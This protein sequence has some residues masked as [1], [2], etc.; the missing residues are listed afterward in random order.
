MELVGPGLSST[1]AKVKEET[2]EVSS[3]VGVVGISGVDGDEN[4]SSES[5]LSL[6]FE[7]SRN[8]N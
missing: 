4:I 1:S 6:W 8:I 7:L 3:A 2:E 5:E